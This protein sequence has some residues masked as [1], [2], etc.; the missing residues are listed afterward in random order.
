MFASAPQ[1][2]WVVR[3]ATYFVQ[4]AEAHV[5]LRSPNMPGDGRFDH[6]DKHRVVR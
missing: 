2:V 6:F 3:Q 4:V 1:V 5:R